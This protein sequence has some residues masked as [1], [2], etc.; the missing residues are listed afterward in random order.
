MTTQAPHE[1]KYQNLIL[2]CCHAVLFVLHF[3]LYLPLYDVI[4]VLSEASASE[5]TLILSVIYPAHLSLLFRP[6]PEFEGKMKMQ[7]ETYIAKYP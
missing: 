6:Q 4:R 7:W 5:R 1:D 3:R 2:S